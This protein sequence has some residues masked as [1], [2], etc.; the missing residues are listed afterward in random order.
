MIDAAGAHGAL[1]HEGGREGSPPL[2]CQGI[3]LL[4]RDDE[5]A[6]ELSEPSEAIAAKIEVPVAEEK[7]VL[8][9][10][11]DRDRSAPGVVE[12]VVAEGDGGSRTE[13]GRSR[14]ARVASGERWPMRA[15]A[16]SGSD[17]GGTGKSRSPERRR[18]VR[19]A[20]LAQR[21]AEPVVRPR[22]AAPRGDGG[23]LRLPPDE[24]GQRA[25]LARAGARPSAGSGRQR[26]ADQ[27]VASGGAP[28]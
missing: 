27:S 8:R 21:A 15:A 20:T 5:R 24:R 16:S 25:S 14:G 28:S 4:R 11:D 6:A 18:T 23:D 10:A 22:V 12:E 7:S 17:S 9:A 3:A 26:V 2:V 19:L 13:P 1:P